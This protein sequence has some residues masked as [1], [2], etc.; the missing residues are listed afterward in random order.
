MFFLSFLLIFATS[1]AETPPFCQK[2]Q[3]QLDYG[4]NFYNIECSQDVRLSLFDKSFWSKSGKPY[5]Y[6]SLTIYNNS[7]YRLDRQFHVSSITILNLQKNSIEYIG[8]STFSNL[9][10]LEK[11]VLSH[12]K[13]TSFHPRAFVVCI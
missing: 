5:L 8:E 12:N 4:S 9:Q 11:L 10:S 2:C 6:K 13:L 7:I 3:C 1:Q